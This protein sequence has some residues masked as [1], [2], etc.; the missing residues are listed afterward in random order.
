MAAI[1]Q[2]EPAQTPGPLS[3]VLSQMP[4]NVTVNVVSPPSQHQLAMEKTPSIAK[5]DSQMRGK[6]SKMKL[7][8]S[9][10]PSARRSFQ[11]PVGL[12]KAPSHP[13]LTT[14]LNQVPSL[15]QK[16]P[17]QAMFVIPVA[18][19]V[20]FIRRPSEVQSLEPKITPTPLPR[21]RTSLRR[22]SKLQLSASKLAAGLP[23]EPPTLKGQLSRAKIG[24]PTVRS[25]LPQ[26]QLLTELQ[27]K[28]DDMALAKSVENAAVGGMMPVQGTF[29]R[30]DTGP[31][32]QVFK[33]G[34]V[35]IHKSFSE[36][37]SS[38]NLLGGLWL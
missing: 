30:K 13:A 31:V 36:R 37:V 12:P 9:E 33:S 25:E 6:S 11:M 23:M 14:P 28:I 35:E 22:L 19:P 4:L 15:S 34:Y 1:A 5:T 10:E 18:P 24:P 3:P 38:C 21:S 27:R 20:P 16:S 8:T 2:I 7:G 17:S 29:P 32:S 26:F